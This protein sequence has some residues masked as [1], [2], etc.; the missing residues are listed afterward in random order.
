M[1][2]AILIL[3][4]LHRPSDATVLVDPAT[5]MSVGAALDAASVS[6]ATS[7]AAEVA[8]AAAASADLKNMKAGQH[9]AQVLRTS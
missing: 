9:L 7:D 2:A 1:A 4:S 6:A 3:R 5:I 8:A